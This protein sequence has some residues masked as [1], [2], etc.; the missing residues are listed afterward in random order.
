MLHMPA[1]EGLHTGR[2]VLESASKTGWSLRRFRERACHAR[3]ATLMIA[4]VAT[5]H[6]A[7]LQ[8]RFDRLASIGT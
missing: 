8:L 4:K 6:W 3:R 7:M 5:H 1:Y 2:C